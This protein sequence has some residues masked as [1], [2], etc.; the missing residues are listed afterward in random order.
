MSWF[1][2]VWMGFEMSVLTSNNLVFDFQFLYQTPGKCSKVWLTN[3]LIWQNVFWWFL[4]LMMLKKSLLVNMS[5]TGLFFK[6]NFTVIYSIALYW[7]SIHRSFLL[8][9]LIESPLQWT[10][11]KGWHAYLSLFIALF[12]SLFVSLSLPFS[13]LSVPFTLPARLCS[14]IPLFHFGQV[15][16]YLFLCFTK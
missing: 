1:W 13:T 14:H 6:H 11:V 10:D 12:L 2:I 16:R 7:N 8:S 5:S 4:H 15:K 3:S 9:S